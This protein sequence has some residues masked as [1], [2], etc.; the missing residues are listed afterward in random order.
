MN[1][2]TI[3]SEALL[4]SGRIVN[5]LALGKGLKESLAEHGPAAYNSLVER[6]ASHLQSGQGRKKRYR[7]R[8]VKKTRKSKSLKKNRQKF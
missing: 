2:K 4:T 5:D 8:I 3:G 6:A 7:R 1:G